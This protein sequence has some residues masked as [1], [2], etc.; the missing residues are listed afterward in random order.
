MERINYYIDELCYAIESRNNSKKVRTDYEGLNTAYSS[1][2]KLIGNNLD[3]SLG[4]LNYAYNTLLNNFNTW[5]DNHYD[6]MQL[7]QIEEVFNRFTKKTSEL[8]TGGI[9]NNKL[10]AFAYYGLHAINCIRGEYENAL[11]NLFRLFIVHPRIAR[12]SLCYDIYIGIIYPLIP[13]SE[14]SELHNMSREINFKN[15]NSMTIDDLRK[16]SDLRLYRLKD[17]EQRIDDQCCKI[18]ENI[19][20][21]IINTGDI[22]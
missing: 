10:K 12:Y 8:H 3:F 19:L 20:K 11:C 9:K 18:S 17:L 5:M 14:K 2:L 15:S 1:L 21:E 13:I 16:D 22:L 6:N 7:Y 4:T